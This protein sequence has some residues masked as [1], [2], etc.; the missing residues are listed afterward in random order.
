MVV[1]VADPDEGSGGRKMRTFEPSGRLAKT[2]PYTPPQA[3][4][5]MGADPQ[6]TLIAPPPSEAVWYLRCGNWNG[7]HSPPH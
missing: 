5:R 7:S 6:N 3:V 2:P 4:T 1:P